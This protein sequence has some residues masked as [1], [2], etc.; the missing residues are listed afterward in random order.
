MSFLS[1]LFGGGLPKN[2]DSHSREEAE[3]LIAE[4]I[5]IG[6]RDD[7]LAERPGAGFDVQCHHIRT[8]QIGRRLNEIGGVALMQAARERIRRKLKLNMASHLDY[9]WTDIGGWKH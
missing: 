7:F 3:K 8:R 9:A 4:L 5:V 2:L 6:K 1:S